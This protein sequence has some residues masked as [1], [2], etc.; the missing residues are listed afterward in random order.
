MNR[1]ALSIGALVLHLSVFY[2]IERLDFGETNLIDMGSPIYVLTLVSILLILFVR[3][4]RFLSIFTIFF[5]SALLFVVIKLFFANNRPV[6]GGIYIYLTITE[7]VFYATAVFLARNLSVNLMDFEQVIRNITF[8]DLKRIKRINDVA[9]SEEIKREFYRSRRYQNLLS[10]IV[11]EQN[12]E[13][14]QIQLNQLVQDVQKTMMSKYIAVN[15]AR[16]LSKQLR[17]TDM[18]FEHRDNGKLVILSPEID[19]NTS[20][21]IIERIN[22][23]AKEVGVDIKC[24]VAIFPEQALT[25]EHLLEKAEQVFQTS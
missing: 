4:E 19:N 24:G 7:F 13:S 16:K 2:N 1:M 17:R 15:L 22:Q 14:V 12:M 10:L 18:I 25:F 3:S 21:K 20:K 8:A 23:V 9:A 6:V 5:S 11:I